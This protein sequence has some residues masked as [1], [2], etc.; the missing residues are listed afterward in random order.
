M[1]GLSENENPETDFKRQYVENFA[2]NVNSTTENQMT[3]GQG[4]HDHVEK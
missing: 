1:F 4:F 3:V 2:F